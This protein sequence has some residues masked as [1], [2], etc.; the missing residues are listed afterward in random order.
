MRTPGADVPCSKWEAAKS[1]L[2]DRLGPVHCKGSQR[3]E[4]GGADDC[5]HQ[6]QSDDG[7]LTRFS[8]LFIQHLSFYKCEKN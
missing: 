1:Q 6:S 5:S 7:R 2:P 8:L 3:G 4:K